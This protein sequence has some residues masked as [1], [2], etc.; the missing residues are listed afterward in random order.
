MGRRKSK[1]K[2]IPNR[3]NGVP[4]AR[5]AATA[6]Q[7][8]ALDDRKAAEA[9]IKDQQRAERLAADRRKGETRRLAEDRGEE[10]AE[11]ASGALHVV[12]RDGL[13]WM[14]DKR[15]ILWSHWEAGMRFREDWAVAGRDGVGSCLGSG[16]MAPGAFGPK[17]G[18]S[19]QML[20]A[21]DKVKAAFA[22][23]RTPMLE[24]YVVGVAAEGRMLTDPLFG[25]D[26]RRSAEHLL[27]CRIAMDL[28]ARH[29]GMI[30]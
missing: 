28:L 13:L 5:L 24:V 11:L 9:A 21:R 22:A 17:S 27:P 2:T 19:D 3:S 8:A 4:G 12:S 14:R 26:F 10:V 30:R 25:K 15:Q 16:G 6:A 29:Y 23:L 20:L 1:G 7:R 18:P